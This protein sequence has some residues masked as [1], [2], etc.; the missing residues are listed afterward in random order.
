M[1]FG[2]GY[3]HENTITVLFSDPVNARRISQFVMCL[4]IYAEIQFAVLVLLLILLTDILP[5]FI[6]LTFQA[7]RQFAELHR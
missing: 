2:K 4:C 7:M 1:D 5:D 6:L 3:V